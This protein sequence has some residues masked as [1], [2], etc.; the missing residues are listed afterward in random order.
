[1]K[2]IQVGANRGYDD[3]YN[4]LKNNKVDVE[5]GILVECFIPHIP[6]LKECYSEFNNII[7]ENIA[8]KSPYEQKDKLNFFYNDCDGP[9]YECA[10]LNLQHVINHNCYFPENSK[11]LSCEVSCFTLEQLFQKYNINSLD[12]LSLDVEGIDSEIILTFDFEK[13]DIKRI[14]FEHIHLGYYKN[15]IKHMM[16]GLGYIQTKSLHEYDWAFEKN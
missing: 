5:M 8:I 12:W 15:S 10:S 13:Y 2:F 9:N 14:E 6:V 1:M 11:I 7:I 3:F 16:N 4:Y